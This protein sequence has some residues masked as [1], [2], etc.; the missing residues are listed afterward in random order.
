MF[1]IDVAVFFLILTLVKFVGCIVDGIEF[2]YSPLSLL[3]NLLFSA[4]YAVFSFYL[5][6]KTKVG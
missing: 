6:R 4:L 3:L 1:F 2:N 5:I